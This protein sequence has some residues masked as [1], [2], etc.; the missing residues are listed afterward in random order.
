MTK[1]KVE[2]INTCSCCASY[3]D[4]IRQVASKLDDAVEVKIYEVGKDID[5]IKKYGMITKG[6]M[7]INE[8]KRYEYLDRGV[9]E[10]A[11]RDAVQ[12]QG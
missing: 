3:E 6:T 10:K 12:E 9:I 8:K 2:F 7:I 1:V 5:Y 11:I 4:M